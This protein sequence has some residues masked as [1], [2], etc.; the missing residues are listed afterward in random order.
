[1]PVIEVKNINKSFGATHVLNDINF[2]VEPG[3]FSGY[4]DPT[5][6]EKQPYS[7]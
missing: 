1:M 5:A 7:G 3:D 4:S 2:K 6:Q